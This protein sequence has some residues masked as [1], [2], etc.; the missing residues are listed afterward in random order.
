MHQCLNTVNFDENAPILP[1]RDDLLVKLYL[2]CAFLESN[3][4]QVFKS[5]SNSKTSTLEQGRILPQ[6]TIWCLTWFKP[7]ADA[8]LQKSAATVQTATG[9]T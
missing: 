3:L 7:L 4:Y 6:R 5:T 8:Y 1:K 2:P 9:G